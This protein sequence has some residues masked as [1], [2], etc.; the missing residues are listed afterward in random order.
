MAQA[1]KP[2]DMVRIAGLLWEVKKVHPM[3]VTLT[4]C[5]GAYVT[6]RTWGELAAR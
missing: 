1:L 4:R 5:R 3:L 6:V 2:G